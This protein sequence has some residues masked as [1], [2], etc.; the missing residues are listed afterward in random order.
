MKT[1]MWYLT[2]IWE[3]T[4][5]LHSLNMAER[6]S[7]RFSAGK[8][9]VAFLQMQIMKMKTFNC[10]SDIEYVPSSENK[11][12]SEESDVNDSI[13]LPNRSYSKSTEKGFQGICR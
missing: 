5:P 4:H 11:S 3:K 12:G 8:A 7:K 9:P 13:A 6:V 2:Y 10:G 1:T